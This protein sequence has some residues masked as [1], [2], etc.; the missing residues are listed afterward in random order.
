MEQSPLLTVEHLSVAFDTHHV[1]D[2]VS[3][4]VQQGHTVAILGPNGSG[5]STLLRAILGLIP[6]QG[7]VA[8]APGIRMAYVPQTLTVERSLPLTV[9]EFFL[10]KNMRGTDVAQALRDVGVAPEPHDGHS[11]LHQ[12]LGTLS[13]GQLQRILIAWS[14]ID[15]PNVLLFDEPTSGIDVGGQQNIYSLLNAI[16][17]ERGLTILLIS[18]DL[19][20]VFSHADSVLCINKTLTCQ[21]IPSEALDSKALASLYGKHVSVYSHHHE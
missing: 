19:H 11:I 1:L 8:W 4:T 5:K 9:A 7:R 3:F 16:K 10:L 17:K 12:P 20:V 13:G 14:I 6:Y 21:G 2:D 15:K 18:H